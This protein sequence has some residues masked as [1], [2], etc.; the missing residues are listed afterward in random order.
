MNPVSSFSSSA[1]RWRHN[2]QALSSLIHAHA[3]RAGIAMGG[4]PSLP[5][6][7]ARAPEGALLISANEHGC[8][9]RRCDFIMACDDLSNK[10]L[11]APDGRTVKIRDLG[12]PIIS[13]RRSIAD[14]YYS[15]APLNNSGICAAWALWVMG[16]APILLAGM[17]CFQGGTYFHNHKA[18]STGNNLQL[19]HHLN[20]WRRLKA[21]IPRAPIRSLGGP[22]AEVFPAYDPAEAF[23]PP[24][25]RAEIESELKRNTVKVIHR[26]PIGPR[27][28]EPGQIV[29]VSDAELAIGLRKRYCE[30][31]PV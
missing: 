20:K 25:D 12:T 19:I 17:D 8:F 18:I 4:G 2:V 14:V 30:R 23:P 1:E 11:K 9:L 6:Q 21:K 7:V 15:T 24:A 31:I 28:F 26:W 27:P 13:S 3:G 22:T 16:C 29:E 5:E 10:P